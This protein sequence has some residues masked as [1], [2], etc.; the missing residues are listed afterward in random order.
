MLGQE[1]L[2]S[3]NFFWIHS[4]NLNTFKY[5][6][7]FVSLQYILEA[8]KYIFLWSNML[9]CSLNFHFWPWKKD[10]ECVQKYL[11]VLKNIWMCSKTFECVQKHLNVFKNHAVFLFSFSLTWWCLKYFE[12]LLLEQVYMDFH[13]WKVPNHHQGQKYSGQ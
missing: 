2:Y 1:K 9:F 10:I 3:Y 5:Y 12:N 6:K 4:K 7:C 13:F 8:H 11:S